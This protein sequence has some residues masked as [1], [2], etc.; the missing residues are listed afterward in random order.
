M[1]PSP[2][3]D[4]NQRLTSDRAVVASARPT[5]PPASQLTWA[6]LW[7]MLWWW[8][9]MVSTRALTSRG[10]TDPMAAPAMMASR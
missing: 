3:T 6:R 4:P 10:G 9:L 1:I 8:L 7:L 5:M 2:I